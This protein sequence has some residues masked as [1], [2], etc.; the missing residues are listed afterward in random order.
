MLDLRYVV[1][2]LDEVAG[3]LALRGESVSLDAIPAAA[4]RRRQLIGAIE[5]GRAELNTASKAM[6]SLPKDSEDFDAKRS[7]LRSLGDR[8]KGEEAELKVVEIGRAHV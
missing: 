4:T 3:A 1:E 8:I 2:H 6:K 5:A 7:A